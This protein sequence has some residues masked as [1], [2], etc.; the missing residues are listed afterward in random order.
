[1]AADFDGDGWPDIYVACDTSPSLLFRNN[2]D[3]TFTETG[4]GE[5]RGAERGRAGAG[6]HGAGHRRFRYA[7]GTWIFSRRTFSDDT[8]VL[9][10]NNGK[11]IFRDVTLRAGLGRG[12]ALRRLGR[13]RSWIW[14]TTG[15]RIFLHDRHGLS[16]SGAKLPDA[17]YKTPN[18]LFRNLADG[19]FE[20]LLDEAGPAMEE[21]H[22]S[23][24]VA[25]GDFD[26]D[27]DIDILIMN[28]NEPPSLLRNDVSGR[29]TGSRCCWWGRSRTAARSARRWWL[30]TATGGRRRRC[31]RNRLISR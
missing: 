20:E 24:G 8:N 18:V 16:R 14:T 26:N 10:R 29:I 4:P 31:W 1:M 22:S 3:G 11:G 25:F 19:K 27:G 21:V 9:Y 6:G 7:M 28:M 17:P 30:R 5:R 13:R 23:R 2:H 12:D 15:C